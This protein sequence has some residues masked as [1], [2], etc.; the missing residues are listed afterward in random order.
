MSRKQI[1]VTHPALSST[2]PAVSNIGPLNHQI[3]EAHVL[4]QQNYGFAI[5]LWLAKDHGMDI[6]VEP[7]QAVRL[8]SYQLFL[9]VVMR[10]MGLN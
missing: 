9:R 8:P 5:K 6:A 4:A 3:R 10:D 7:L 2:M 1:I